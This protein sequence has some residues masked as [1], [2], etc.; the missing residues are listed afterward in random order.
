M[1]IALIGSR[2]L[3]RQ[4]QYHKDILICQKLCYRLAELGITFV[5][6]LCK[7]GMD[8][9]A[10]KMY[11]KALSEGLVTTD[12]FEVYVADQKEIDYSPLPNKHLAIIR[13]PNLI[14]ETEA[15]T[16]QLLGERHW[17]RCNEYARGMHSRNCHQILGYNLDNPVDAVCTWTPN[18][19]IQGGTKTALLLAQ[20]HDIPI[21]NLGLPDRKK[22]LNDLKLFL[23]QNDY[24]R[25]IPS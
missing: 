5:S 10:Q 22:V 13:N 16:E 15:L 18:G 8:G 19:N 7:D 6:G 17:S 9:I 25:K 3:E 20:A 12:H 14:K 21:F 2:D 4:S 11:S 23:E 1:R 24:G